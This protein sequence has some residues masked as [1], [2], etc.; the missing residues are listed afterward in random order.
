MLSIG[1]KAI[2]LGDSTWNRCSGPSFP[3]STENRTRTGSSVA[4]VEDHQVVAAIAIEIDGTE[5]PRVARGVG[6]P[7]GLAELSLGVLVDEHQLVR[8]Q[9]G[10]VGLA[11]AVQ[12]AY[13]Q[14]G[15]ALDGLTR[16]DPLGLVEF[17]A[18]HR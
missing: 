2:A 7:L 10:Q 1:A 18:R 8:L 4:A 15:A 5:H 16:V 14:S 6:E 9:Q 3:P 12:V 11:V 17:A 13:R